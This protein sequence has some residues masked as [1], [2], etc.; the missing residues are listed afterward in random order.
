MELILGYEILES[1]K[2]L[3]YKAWYA[4]AEFIDNS[5]QSYRNNKEA[6]NQLY[7]AEGRILT[8]EIIYQTSGTDSFVKIRDNAWGM[9][10]SDLQH[11][12]TLGKIPLNA[13]E[14]SKFGLGLKTAAFWFGNE[15]EVKTT[16]F[17]S[18]ELLI[19]RVNLHEILLAEKAHY[20]RLEEESL[21]IEQFRPELAIT[22]QETSP[23]THGTE[24]EIRE[25]SK[26][27]T[28]N[29][30]TSCIEYLQSIY[31][32]DIQNNTLDLKFQDQ[33]L[34]WNTALI[35]DMLLT[36]GSG[37]IFKKNINITID[38][39]NVTG[40]AGILKSGGKKY[41]GFSLLQAD[42]VIMGYPKAYKNNSLFGPEDGGRND[43]TN[44]RLVGELFL[45]K[46]FAVSHTKDQ[47]LFADHEE[48][49]LDIALFE[50]LADYKK[51]A[52]IPF[53]NR[54]ESEV[55]FENSP[56]DFGAATARVLQNL[57]SD[58]FRDVLRNTTVLPAEILDQT[59]DETVRRILKGDHRSFK[60][61]LDS[62]SVDI[63]L[64]E[65]SSPYD[66]YLIVRPAGGDGC[67]FIIINVNHS[68]WIDLGDN[69]SRFHFLLNCIYDGVAEWKAEFLLSQLD[70]NT[71]KLIKDSLLRLE[72]T[73][74]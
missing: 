52:N 57:D 49:E 50:C 10:E 5:T 48:D 56:F 70:P 13:D 38:G 40:W 22:R 72:L 28:K 20:K 14:R 63:I 33:S 16:Q 71:I 15:W 3:P 23:D 36:D 26:K 66:P 74:R 27:I 18:N 29:S 37:R 41:G 73:I 25:L 1:Y 19:V 59:N 8:V 39:K 4:L 42:R 51:E 9:N 6:L 12:L 65:S 64:S 61:Q 24:I 45:D 32:V 7:G 55:A 17:G 31:R 53:K 60:Y 34:V 62:L 69:T 54:G 44:Q 46:E 35:N 58:K 11:A 43:L 68:Y 30:S 21:P 47:I 67:L 2:R